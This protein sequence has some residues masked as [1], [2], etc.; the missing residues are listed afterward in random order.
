MYRIGKIDRTR[1]VAIAT[2][3]KNRFGID[4]RIIDDRHIIRR[5]LETTDIFP[6]KDKLEIPI[7]DEIVK[8]A[9]KYGIE[10]EWFDKS[11]GNKKRKIRH[12]SQDEV[13]FILENYGRMR[14]KDIAKHLGR[15]PASVYNKIWWLKKQGKIAHLQG[16]KPKYVKTTERI[17]NR[18]IH[19]C[20]NCQYG[21]KEEVGDYYWCS[22]FNR[23]VLPDG[24]PVK[25]EA[26]A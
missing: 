8:T 20:K 26:I 2:Y 3:L 19:D 11:N 17:R 15:D 9:R 12:F 10:T 4:Y 25:T 5:I 21:R 14:T 24:T 1:I 6:D 7:D 16:R 23:R 13:N 22:K 18:C